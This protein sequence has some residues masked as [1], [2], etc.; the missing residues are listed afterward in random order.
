MKILHFRCGSLRIL[1]L[2]CLIVS[3]QTTVLADIVKGR[4]VDAETKEPL[5]EASVKLTQ[6]YGD[7]G[8]MITSLK[9]DS[10]GCFTFSAS[11]RGSS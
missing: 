1:F 4:V 10:I 8:T 6:R 11:G 2:L 7:Y 3:N 5:P 9:A